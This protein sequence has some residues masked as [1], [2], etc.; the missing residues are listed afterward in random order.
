M[1]CIF[2]PLLCDIQFRDTAKNIE[3]KNKKEYAV[4]KKINAVNYVYY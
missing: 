3:N 4:Q 2:P 1:Y